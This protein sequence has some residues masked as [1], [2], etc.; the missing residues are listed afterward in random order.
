MKLKQL[1]ANYTLLQ[2]QDLSQTEVLF[3]YETPVAINWLGSEWT[4][5]TEEKYSNTTTSHIKKYLKE[6]KSH[7]SDS[8]NHHLYKEV[9]QS[10]IEDRV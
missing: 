1:G 6:L 10:W 5:I 8:D 3:S 9:S 7:G 4:F 2:K